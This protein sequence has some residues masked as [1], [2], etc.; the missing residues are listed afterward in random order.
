MSTVRSKRVNFKIYCLHLASL[1]S[2]QRNGIE[3]KGGNNVLKSWT[4]ATSPLCTACEDQQCS[5]REGQHWWGSVGITRRR[6]NSIRW[7]MLRAEEEKKNRCV[8]R[9]S[10][11]LCIALVERTM[12]FNGTTADNIVIVVGANRR[13]AH[14]QQTSIHV[15]RW[16]LLMTQRAQKFLSTTT[17]LV[18]PRHLRSYHAC[19]AFPFP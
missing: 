13:S 3:H 12:E 2:C 16:L 15:N 18:S 1:N 5:R 7:I 6:R 4:R 14:A 17:C 8:S 10:D 11:L 9:F 19:I